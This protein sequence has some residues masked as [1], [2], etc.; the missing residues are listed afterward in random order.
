MQKLV[1]RV[2]DQL[3]WWLFG[4]VLI[5]ALISENLVNTQQFGYLLV[6]VVVVISIGYFLHVPVARVRRILHTLNR[7]WL[8]IAIIFI[9]QIT[10]I[11]G[12]SGQIGYDGATVMDAA[13]GNP[14]YYYFSIDPNNLGLLFF[15]RCIFIASHAL[16][17]TNFI[18]TLNVV[19]LLMV[20]AAVLL[21]VIGLRQY[22]RKPVLWSII[23]F[24]FLTAPWI[25]VFYTD[26][27]VLPL[28]A[29]MIVIFYKL[30]INFRNQD[31]SNRKIVLLSL[32]WGITTFLSYLL[33]PSS[34]IFVMAVVIELLILLVF[35]LTKQHFKKT[36]LN[37]TI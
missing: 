28:V 22:L 15:E 29:G 24:C 20:D 2:L 10:L 34:L 1:P 18:L 6:A 16:G 3:C 14:N 25:V 26:T 23:P 37:K 32:M 17:V 4:I 19:N 36:I 31:Y 9:Y 27:T 11:I 21:I 8:M 5:G 13:K 35:P 12:L 7:P 33:K 30:I